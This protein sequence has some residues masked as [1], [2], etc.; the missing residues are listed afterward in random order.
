MK[1]I[2]TAQYEIN[3]DKIMLLTLEEIKAK[4]K[5]VFDSVLSG[6]SDITD[7]AELMNDLYDHYVYE[8]PYGTAKARTGDPTEWILERLQKDVH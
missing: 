8:M 7:H 1:T 2:K 4:H 3:K 5:S 6:D